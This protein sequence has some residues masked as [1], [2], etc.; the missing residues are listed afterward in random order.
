MLS[1]ALMCVCGAKAQS[2]EVI[3]W[4]LEP[5]N[6]YVEYMLYL[7]SEDIRMMGEKE[8]TLETAEIL[9]GIS[10]DYAQPE[11]VVADVNTL[12]KDV[13]KAWRKFVWLC[14]E[15]RFQ[16]AIEHYSADPL[17][18]DLQLSHSM[19]RYTFHY[20][21]LGFIAYDVLAEDEARRLMANAISID[22]VML[23]CNYAD[24]GDPSYREYYDE[25]YYLLKT[26]Y[27]ELEDYQAAIDL[28]DARAQFLS[29][30]DA[31]ACEIGSLCVAKAEMYFAMGDT[32]GAYNLLTEGKALLEEE[33]QLNGDDEELKEAL[34][35]LDELINYVSQLL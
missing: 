20:D 33:F 10:D 29:V 24:T 25:S 14:N 21:V 27:L 12:Y 34:E 13:E 2:K 23:G 31:S 28:I 15:E 6:E 19:I 5:K 18:V 35:A 7:E 16:E 9:A 11:Q 30:E 1:V 4:P 22:C 26:L 3:P 8:F 32:K 17:M